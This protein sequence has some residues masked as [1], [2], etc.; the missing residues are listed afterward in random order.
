MS[1]KE[2]FRRRKG[3]EEGEEEVRI[4]K[5]FSDKLTRLKKLFLIEPNQRADVSDS[6]CVAC[7]CFELILLISPRPSENR[8]QRSLLKS[9]DEQ[10]VC[11]VFLFTQILGNFRAE[12]IFTPEP[13]LVKPTNARRFIV[14]S[15]SLTAFYTLYG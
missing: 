7:A 15:H 11:E 5:D 1:R 8:S 12:K 10:V 13:N 14:G 2:S 4:A 6:G 3:E 9:I